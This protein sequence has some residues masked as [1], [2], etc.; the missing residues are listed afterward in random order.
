MNQPTPVP[1]ELTRQHIIAELSQHYAFDNLTD[2]ALEERLDRA[3]Q[4]TTLDE[5]RGLVS[6]L[7]VLQAQ[8]AS[9]TGAAPAALPRHPDSPERQVV[10]GVM[11]GVERKGAWAPADTVYA[12]AVMGGVS[13]DFR[14]AHLPAGITNVV[15]IAIMGGAEIIV[16]PSVHVDLNGFA[17]MGGFGQEGVAAGAA[18]GAPIL[19]VG[20]I[21]L[22]GGVSV[23]VRLAGESSGQARKREKLAARQRQ[24]PPG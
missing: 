24:L 1:L 20:G 7:P 15:V 11:G 3:F 2:A 5:L 21:A 9:A 12:I 19:R 17:L 13:L 22:M 8:P 16:P 6:D 14:E 23:E 10:I 4:A 18:P